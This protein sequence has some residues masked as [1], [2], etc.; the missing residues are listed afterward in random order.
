MSSGLPFITIV[1]VVPRSGTSLMMQMLAAGGLPPLID[2]Q[3]PPDP[4]NPRGYYEFEPVKRLRLDSSWLDQARG[5]AVKIIHLLLRELPTDGRF[6]YRV[7]MMRRP[8]EAIIASQG[9]MLERQGKKGAP[10]EVLK[11]TYEAQLRDVQSWLSKYDCFRSMDVDY[12]ELLSQPL[13]TARS[14]D[15]FVDGGLDVSAMAAAVNPS[16]RHHST[17]DS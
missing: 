14:V 12:D 8:L 13:E 5:R 7:L 16:L 9:A 17:G 6:N 15:A 10:A 3:R 1:S 2:D 11:P 4:S